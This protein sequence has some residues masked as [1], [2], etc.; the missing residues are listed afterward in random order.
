MAFHMALFSSAYPLG[1][2][3]PKTMAGVALDIFTNA[4]HRGFAADDMFVLIPLPDG[5]ARRNTVFIDATRGKRV[6]GPKDF[7]QGRT[8]TRRGAGR[9]FIL[10]L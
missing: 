2:H 1:F 3:D 8:F 5:L 4:L 7:R 9:D 6:E 10:R